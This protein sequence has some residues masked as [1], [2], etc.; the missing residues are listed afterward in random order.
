M[1]VDR[2]KIL[3]AAQKHLSKGH[4]DRAIAEYQK[5]VKADPRDVRTLLKIG[6]LY[7]RKG[8]HHEATATYNRVAEHYAKQGF[9]LKAVAVYKQILKLQPSRNDVSLRLAE[10]YENLQLVSDALSTYEQAASAFARE[11]DIDRA[12]E[13]L[14][15]MAALDPENIPVRI[16]YAEALSKAGRREEAGNEFEAGA[17]LL[18]EQ[19]RMDDYVKVAERLLYHRP[20][21]SDLARTLAELY[22]QRSDAKRAL[23]KLQLCFK[24]DPKNVDTLELL[25]RAF[26]VL[27]QT[28]KTVSVYRE[29]ARIHQEAGRPEERARVLK[30]ILELDP[31]D[32]E[33]RQA[34]AGF[35]PSAKRPSR[36][37]PRVD[38]MPPGAVVDSGSGMMLT[39]DDP[40]LEIIDEPDDSLDDSAVIPPTDDDDDDIMIVEEDVEIDMMAMEDVDDPA[41]PRTSPTSIPPDVAREAQIA[42]LLTECDVFAR[43]GLKSKVIAQLEQVIQL[44][45]EHVEARERLKD[46]YL[47]AN[48]PADAA[49]QLRALAE[50]FSDKPQVAQMYERRA[51]ELL[52][53]PSMAPPPPAAEDVLII[54][55]DLASSAEYD[56][57]DDDESDVTLFVDDPLGE[58]EDLEA[59]VADI[60]TH[61]LHTPP[62]PAD[63]E[64]DL[65]FVDDAIEVTSLAPSAPPQASASAEVLEEDTLMMEGEDDILFLDDEPEET[66]KGPAAVRDLRIDDQ[67]ST[68][69]EEVPPP[70]PMGV[71]LTE[72]MGLPQPVT[73]HMDIADDDVPEHTVIDTALRIPLGTQPGHVPDIAVSL[74]AP[75]SPDE[76]EAAP[77]SA[78]GGHVQEARERLS[79]PPGEIEETLD[80]ADFFLAQGLFDAAHATVE[81]ALSSNPGHPLLRDKLQEIAEMRNA[82]L[83]SQLPPAPTEPQDE[84]FALAEKLAEELG[85]DDVDDLSGSDVLDVDSVFEQFKKGVQEQI[86]LEDTDTHFDL[87]IA[88]KEM[89]LLDD[90][91]HEFELAMANPQRECICQTMIG[92]CRAEQ[93]R[94]T[95]A[96]GHY[97]KGLY[98]E[99]KTEREELGLYYELG[100]A[101]EQLDDPKEALYYF[102]KVAKR[103][104]G[105]R[106]VEARIKALSE[107]KPAVAAPEP[108]VL[109]DVDSA[110]DDLLSED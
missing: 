72:E 36:P 86:G 108:L 43:Y 54:E 30:K 110:F 24:Q 78:P 26:H 14:G 41:P 77:V 50:L 17:D 103:A 12:L 74:E 39:E 105:F 68:Q 71:V 48:R 27:G 106:E 10:M 34:L 21:D 32:A 58:L 23:A 33:A 7:T 29:M 38:S 85:D 96:I 2:T 64:D 40:E 49:A 31:N 70:D 8:A 90:A 75:I 97:K 56:A 4:Y 11:G 99:T 88:Y 5:L 51:E 93:G 80:E 1:A 95:D 19:G 109:D 20:E 107:P 82:A 37:A 63:D 3:A 53:T 45:P 25:A 100:T 22:L 46:A 102:Q 67:P 6:D 61:D 15:K 44:A 79:I 92:L 83:S 59:E 66:A 35:A 73:P 94:L 16:K 47:E 62:P 101:Y 57:L 69:S 9:F 91:I 60:P 76:F 42:R 13:T 98:A 55:E 87:G 104:P 84:A 28:P 52:Q 89:G 65:I 18:R 81:D